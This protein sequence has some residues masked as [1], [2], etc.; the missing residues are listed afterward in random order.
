MPAALLFAIFFG[1]PS[2][3][4]LKF[5]K[6]FSKI[7]DQKSEIRQI[8]EPHQTQIFDKPK[9]GKIPNNFK[10]IDPKKS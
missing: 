1:P 8:S 9:P 7:R 6:K 2:F 4:F 5:V 10:S 3:G